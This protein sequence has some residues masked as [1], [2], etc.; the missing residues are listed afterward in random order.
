MFVGVSVIRMCGLVPLVTTFVGMPVPGSV[1]IGR[2]GL[3]A[4][5]ILILLGLVVRDR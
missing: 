3:I 2:S 4:L 5:S 1:A